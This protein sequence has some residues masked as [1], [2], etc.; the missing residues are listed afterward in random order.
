ML[1]TKQSEWAI[2]YN[3]EIEWQNKKYENRNVKYSIKKLWIDEE[4]G[5]KNNNAE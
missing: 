1:I 3:F 5:T 2:R 4:A